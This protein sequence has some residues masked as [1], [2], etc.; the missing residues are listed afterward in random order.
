V[1]RY[2]PAE[3][4]ADFPAL[5]RET[6]EGW[7]DSR[8][9]EKSLEQREGCP[10][11]VFYDGPP[12]TNGKPH[13]GHM[14]QSSLKDLWPRYKTMQGFRV[15][16]KAGWDTHGLPVELKAER[17]LGIEDKSQIPA[18]GVEKFMDYCR[19]TVFRYKDDWE[20]S[21]RRIGR[22]LD[23]RDP[24]ATLTNEYIQTDWW[25]IRQIWDKGLLYRDYRIMPYCARCGTGLSNFEVTEGY[26]DV[27][28][29]TLTVRFPLKGA[30]RTFVLAWTTTP[31]TLVGNTA[32]AMN[33][34]LDYV[35]ARVGDDTLVL[36]KDLVDTVLEGHAHEIVKT[37]KG[38]ELAGLE[39]EPLWDF[40]AGPDTEGRVPHHI[41][42]GDFVTAADGT[43]V[44]HLALYGEDDYRMIKRDN[45]P[46]IQHVDETGHFTAACGVYAGRYFKAEGLDLEILKDLQ[47]RGL[48]HHKHKHAHSYPHCYKCE[49]PADVL[50]PHELV[51]PHLGDARADAGRQ[52]GHQLVPGLH[53]GRAFRQLAR[54][55]HRLERE[56]RPLLGQPAARVDLHL[57][58]PAEC[59]GGM[60]DLQRLVNTPLPADL[61]LH[62]PP[63]STVWRSAARP[64][65]HP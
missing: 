8:I 18:F 42:M 23:M 34:D 51:H 19:S 7:A 41:L 39:Y 50:R 14:L 57:R 5:E 28:D 20:Q 3:S 64:V 46:R 60:A 31:W 55:Q 65:T 15:L 2:I 30:E 56:P 27:I 1:S 49:K 59:V 13:I 32:L 53:Q 52:R 35:Y 61:D 43:G 33:P 9:F 17:E 54:E 37:V 48:L 6:L 16:R 62:M 11:W 22:F 58:P 36:A 38:H 21:I 29:L 40:F 24:Y 45:L 47:S 10:D 25:V 26:K 12:G 44:V 63:G 4:Q